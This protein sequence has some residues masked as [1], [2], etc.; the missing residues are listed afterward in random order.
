MSFRRMPLIVAAALLLCLS[1]GIAPSHASPAQTR[2]LIIPGQYVGTAPFSLMAQNLASRGY[3]TTV[4]DLKG[5]EPRSDARAIAAAVDRERAA[6]PG[7]KIALVGHSIGG[8]SARWYLKEL[9]GTDKVATY[10]AIGAPQYGSSAACT[11]NVGRDVCPGSAFLTAINKGD[12]APGPTEYFSIRSAREYATG[13]LDGGQC[14]VWP[15]SAN[16]SL[17]AMGYEHTFE[18]FDAR[19][20]DAVVASLHGRCAGRFVVDADNSLSYQ[21]S[22]LPGAPGYRKL[23]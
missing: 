11:Q 23:K 7:A 4:L 22:L 14:R 13:D 8:M 18:P 15:I 9:G 19:V 1:L 2:V 3:P 17:P 20:W 12:D 21:K 6:H 10:V 16:E 5:F